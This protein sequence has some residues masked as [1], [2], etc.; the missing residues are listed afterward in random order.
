MLEEIRVLLVDNYDSFTYNLK[1]LILSVIPHVEVITNN[2]PLVLEKEDFTHLILSPGPKD[3][4]D[5]GYCKE[6]IHKW[7]AKKPILGVCL[8]HQVLAEVY[9]GETVKSL[10]PM[11][12]KISP[13]THDGSKLFDEIPRVFKAARYHSLV[14][15]RETIP[16]SLKIVAEYDNIIMALSHR[17]H[18]CLHGVQFHP[19]SFLSE[20]G[21][22]LMTNFLK[23]TYKK[24]F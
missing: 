22:N 4:S 3:P 14:V 7:G 17:E 16:S 12:G 8:G 9:G 5:S 6:L 23:M 11:H 10:Y 19:E 1:Q 20:G 24:A 18:E 13:M 2:N 21:K 15:K